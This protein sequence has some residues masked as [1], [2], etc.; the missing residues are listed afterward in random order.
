MKR[1]KYLLILPMLALLPASTYAKPVNAPLEAKCPP[2][3]VAH[4]AG[5]L[6]GAALAYFSD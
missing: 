6:G 1:T 2:C 3:V 4:A 5:F